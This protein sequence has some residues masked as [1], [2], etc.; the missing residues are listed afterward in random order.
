[1]PAETTELTAQL[2]LTEQ[3]ALELLGSGAGPEQVAAAV[4]VSVSRISQ[5]LA[6]PEFAALVADL[7]FQSLSKHNSRDAAYDSIEDELLERMRNLLPLMMRPMEI[8]RAITVINSAKR[9]GA[10][11]P[12]AVNSQQAIV[13]IVL[14]QVI[15]DRYTTQAITTNAQNQVVKVGDQE[16]I[17]MQSGTLFSACKGEVD[18]EVAKRA[19][20]NEELARTSTAAAT[21]RA[22][23]LLQRAKNQVTVR[24][25]S[26]S[27]QDSLSSF[28]QAG[29]Q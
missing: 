12:T 2:T 9:R 16:L 28:V 26:Q 25:Q 22:R 18:N 24:E 14:P 13:N 10:S 15:L 29:S 7:R 3:R 11:A 20:A 23:E 17:T 1:M 6:D 4:G 19:I 8:L 27:G 5:L 21:E